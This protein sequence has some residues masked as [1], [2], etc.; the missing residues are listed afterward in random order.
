MNERERRNIALADVAFEEECQA[1]LGTDSEM[2]RWEVERWQRYT[3]SD[4]KEVIGAINQLILF[5]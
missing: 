2:T 3:A 5:E 4:S 1:R